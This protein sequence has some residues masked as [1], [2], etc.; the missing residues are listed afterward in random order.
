MDSQG[1]F[2]YLIENG[3]LVKKYVTIGI[4]SEAYIQILD[5]LSQGQ[6]IVTAAVSGMGL[7]EGMA[8]TG[9]P[10]PDMSGAGMEG[11]ETGTA[12]DLQKVRKDLGKPPFS[13][14]TGG[15]TGLWYFRVQWMQLC[16]H[17]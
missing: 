16:N 14:E 8:V 9:M 2:C 17:S 10:M 13:G 15:V 1:A 12:G 6:E 7:D 11:A 5:G 3:V 4:S